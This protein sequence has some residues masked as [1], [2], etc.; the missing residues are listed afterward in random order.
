MRMPLPKKLRFE[1]LKRDGFACQYCGQG[2]PHVVLHVDHVIPVSR[3]GTN[4]PDNLVA[5]C[6]SCNSG[7]RASFHDPMLAQVVDLKA[8]VQELEEALE[9]MRARE[10]IAR[11]QADYVAERLIDIY[12]FDVSP[13]DFAMLADLV[14]RVGQQGAMDALTVAEYDVGSNPEDLWPHAIAVLRREATEW[15]TLL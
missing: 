10:S 2:A 4:D 12:K 5:A 9:A 14:W 15:E 6:E 13:A 3:G 11:D 8:H 1:V 7:K